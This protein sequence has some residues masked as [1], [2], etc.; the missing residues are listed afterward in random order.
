MYVSA[1]LRLLVR[2]TSTTIVIVSRDLNLSAKFSNKII[3]MGKPRVIHSIGKPRDVVTQRIV[4]N[5]HGVNS[6]TIDDHRM[7]HIVL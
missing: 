5:M 7:S 3:V 4:R 1:F 6:E 2:K